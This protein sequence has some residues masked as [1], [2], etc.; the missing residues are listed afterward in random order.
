MNIV[1]TEYQKSSIIGQS[2]KLVE[3]NGCVI[4]DLEND[5]VIVLGSDLIMREISK[6]QIIKKDENKRN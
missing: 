3:R 6:D 2:M 5:K 1:F 4:N